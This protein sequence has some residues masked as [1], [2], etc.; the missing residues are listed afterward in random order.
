MHEWVVGLPEHD[1]SRYNWRMAGRLLIDGDCGFC[2]FCAGF[3]RRW[4]R[5]AGVVQPWQSAEISDLGLTEVDCRQAV[6]WVGADGRVASGGDAVIAT[7]QAGRQPWRILGAGLS[8][9]V[10]RRL[11]DRVYRIVA[12]R[13]TC[14]V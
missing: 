4:I 8:A 1:G 11:V 9:P 12:R 3:T 2:R 7:L 5:P 13:R 6:Q 14:A 10:P